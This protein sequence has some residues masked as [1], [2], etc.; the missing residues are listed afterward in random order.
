[1]ANLAQAE[2]SRLLESML[3]NALNEPAA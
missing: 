2:A 3:H 1:M